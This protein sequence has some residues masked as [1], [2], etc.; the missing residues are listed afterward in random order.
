MRLVVR[1]LFWL[2]RKLSGESSSAAG[3]GAEKSQFEVERKYRLA[4][5]EAESLPG[6]LMENGFRYFRKQVMTDTF[7]PAEEESDM[8]RVRDLTEE[9]KSQII[10]TLKKWVM[11]EGERVRQEREVDSLDPVTRACLLS[12][13]TR[14]AKGDLISFSKTRVEYQKRVDGRVVTVALDDV[15][16][17]GANSGPYMEVEVLAKREEDVKQ[18]SAKVDETAE[19]LLGESR[20]VASS[21]M[22]MLKEHHAKSA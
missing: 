18:A 8:I 2:A 21:Y 4:S 9:G 7:I 19:F 16:G 11:V 22:E 17:L 10:L 20:E 5:S 13:G 3:K 1:F 12:L 15:E 14:I 6:K